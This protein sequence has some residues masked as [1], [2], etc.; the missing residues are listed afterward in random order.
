MLPSTPS[1]TCP[2]ERGHSTWQAVNRVCL[3]FWQHL[4]YIAPQ[5]ENEWKLKIVYLLRGI[6][7][8]GVVTIVYP[9]S[10]EL[11][12]VTVEWEDI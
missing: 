5:E 10:T 11:L 8:A 1:E 2:S 9:N 4:V 12:A 3:L 7:H 6:R